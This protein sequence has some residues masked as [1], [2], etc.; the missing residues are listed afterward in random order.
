MSRRKVIEP[1]RILDAAEAIILERGGQSF[2]LDAVAERAGISKGGLVYTFATKD[3][4]IAAALK[5]EMARFQASVERRA[6]NDSSP[7]R[8]AAQV[9]QTLSEEEALHQMVAFMLTA[10]MHAPAMLAPCRDYYR[11]LLLDFDPSTDAGRRSR[12]AIFAVEGIFLLHGLG[13][14]DLS[15]EYRREI[16]QDAHNVI[17]DA[18]TA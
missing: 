15:P 1:E 9:E 13:L 3:E 4:L 2:T 18:M 11:R 12:L 5:R 7:A 14:A 16:L 8:L 10:L 17:L 6:R